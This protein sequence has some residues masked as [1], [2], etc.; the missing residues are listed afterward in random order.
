MTTAI[1]EHVFDDGWIVDANLR[2]FCETV[3]AFTGYDFDDSDWQA[4]DTALP[5]T[6]E[7]RSLWYD[8]PLSGRVPL[9][10]FVAAD[11]EA[12]VV[13]VRVAG[14]PDSHTRAKLAA[15]RFI[16]GTWEVRSDASAG[17]Y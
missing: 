14:E 3:A 4:I 8:Y 12:G 2:P 9:T 6:D 13:F 16:F 10:L 11:P 1:P 5:H 17:G 15:A 7:E